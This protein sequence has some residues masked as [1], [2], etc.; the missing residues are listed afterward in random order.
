LEPEGPK[1]PV[2]TSLR[3]KPRGNPPP[4]VE[5][6]QKKFESILREN[7]DGETVLPVRARGKRRATRNS[8]GEE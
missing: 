2:T 5:G 7:L 8:A 4:Q 6:A 3:R 1:E